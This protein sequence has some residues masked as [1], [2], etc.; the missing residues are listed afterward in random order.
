MYGYFYRLLFCLFTLKNLNTDY[1]PYSKVVEK[2]IVL[3]NFFYDL[4]YFPQ[5]ITQMSHKLSTL[6]LSKVNTKIIKTRNEKA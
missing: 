2:I 3:D 5:G 6:R 1:F 4:L